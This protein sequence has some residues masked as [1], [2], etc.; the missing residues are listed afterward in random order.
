MKKKF[1]CHYIGGDGNTPKRR[2]IE[3]T[4]IHELL[5]LVSNEGVNTPV[6]YEQEDDYYILYAQLSDNVAVL[7]PTSHTISDRMLNEYLLK[8][9]EDIDRECEKD[10]AFTYRPEAMKFYPMSEERVA[11]CKA[12]K[13]QSYED[14]KKYR[15]ARYA[16]L[17]SYQDYGNRLLVGS[18]V[19]IATIRAFEEVGSPI[20]PF[21]QEIRR[22]A[23]EQREEEQRKELEKRRKEREE[24]ERKKAEERAKEDAK[25]Q[26]LMEMGMLPVKLSAMQ[27]GTVLAG[28]DERGRFE[29]ADGK[30][31]VCTIYELITEHG[32]NKVY[33]ST[34]TH[35]RY[36]E[37]LAKPRNSYGV[38]NASLGYGYRINGHMGAIMVGNK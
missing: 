5:P 23:L 32:F 36:G 14:K 26:T 35:N 33:K 17:R 19:N 31:V 18:W 28:L 6:W 2:N 1:W 37:T 7:I 3:L 15:D 13:R 16:D 10:I 8:T 20:L 25:L 29:V 9:D 22:I 24:E 21:L 27:R 34:E 4:D 30:N 12:F 11:E 38:H